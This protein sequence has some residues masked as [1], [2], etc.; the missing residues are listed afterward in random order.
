M[1]ASFY[2]QSESDD[3]FLLFIEKIDYNFR[4]AKQICEL[5]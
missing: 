2:F 4:S 1:D 5:V 3:C